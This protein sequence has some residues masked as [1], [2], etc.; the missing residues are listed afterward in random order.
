M[1]Y[2][3]LFAGLRC[4]SGWFLKF[5]ALSNA[6]NALVHDQNLKTEFFSA[7]GSPKGVI[8][9]ASF[10]VIGKDLVEDEAGRCTGS[11]RWGV[12]T[13]HVLSASGR[14]IGTTARVSTKELPVMLSPSKSHLAE[15]FDFVH[16]LGADFDERLLYAFICRRVFMERASDG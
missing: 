7:D 1:N 14:E 10:S 15:R 13:D 4:V 8:R 6:L 11:I 12:R 5:H 2:D 3:A 9:E 16:E